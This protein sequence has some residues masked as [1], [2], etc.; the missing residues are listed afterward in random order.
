[1]INDQY[2]GR[3]KIAIDPVKLLNGDVPLKPVAPGESSENKGSG[4]A[5][6]IKKITGQ[7]T[8]LITNK[9][10]IILESGTAIFSFDEFVRQIDE[11]VHDIS[12][13]YGGI[14]Y[15]TEL[16]KGIS[17]IT[18]MLEPGRKSELMMQIS[19]LPEVEKVEEGFYF[20]ARPAANEASVGISPYRLHSRTSNS[21]RVVIKEEVLFGY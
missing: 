7:T 19:Y 3:Y 2:S 14:L 1:M 13:Q 10:D 20:G 12:V 16:W 6:W 8:A 4:E 9:V 11:M 5:V 18:L 17:I 15:A 21:V